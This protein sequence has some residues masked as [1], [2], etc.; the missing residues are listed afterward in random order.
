MAAAPAPVVQAPAAGPPQAPSGGGLR[1]FLGSRNGAILAAGG[2]VALVAVLGLFGRKKGAAD[3]A[4]VPAAFDSTPYDEW[5][6]WE[7]QYDELAG[8][9]STLEHPPGS[10]GPR[11]RPPV[12]IGQPRRTLPAPIP[13]P[14]GFKP[15]IRTTPPI[16]KVKPPTPRVGPLP[17]ARRNVART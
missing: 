6:Q 10:A 15:P 4:T 2:T 14:P 9:V 13:R 1:G 12:P 16:S 5:G 17:V 8:R 3:T 11:P 7:Q